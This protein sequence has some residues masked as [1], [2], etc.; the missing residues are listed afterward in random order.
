MP[1]RP[2]FVALAQRVRQLHPHLGDPARAISE[3]LVRV[4]G[5]IVSNPRAKIPRS[6]AVT[7]AVPPAAPRGARKLTSALEQFAVPVA[8]R[9]AL[10]VGA[11]AGGFTHALLAAG[12]RGSTPSTPGTG[13]SSARSASTAAS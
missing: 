8:G 9:V 7:V 12:A 13:S 4:D 10:D 6:A 11:A 5:M 1:A 3:R 2:R